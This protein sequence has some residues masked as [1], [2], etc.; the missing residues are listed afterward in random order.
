MPSYY[1]VEPSEDGL[2][3]TFTTRYNVKYQLAL[4]TY[5]LGDVNAFSISLYPETE[6][7]PFDYWIKN[8]VIKIIGE[9]LLKDS[10]VVFYVCDS[11]DDREDKRYN[12]FEYWYKKAANTY[13]YISK[14]DYCI[15]SENGYK[16]NS[17]ILYN[18][19]NFLRNYIIDEFKKALEQS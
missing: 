16:L 7:A 4:T 19:D 1:N 18:A 5:L 3:Y 14:F 15:Q 11:D 2:T 8:T 6:P 17:S 10:N 9:I 13:P 12:V